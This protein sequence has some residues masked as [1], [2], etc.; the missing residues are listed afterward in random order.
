LVAQHKQLRLQQ[1]YSSAIGLSLTFSKA[2]LYG[3]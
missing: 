1:F 3:S 2:T